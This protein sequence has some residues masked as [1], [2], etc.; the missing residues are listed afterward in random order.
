MQDVILVILGN[1]ANLTTKTDEHVKQ[2]KSQTCTTL[3]Q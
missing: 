1:L 3:P 2:D